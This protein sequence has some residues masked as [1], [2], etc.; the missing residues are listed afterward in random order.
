MVES[1]KL[2]G[3]TLPSFLQ[4]IWRRGH[5]LTYKKMLVPTYQISRFH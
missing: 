4:V 2:F 5:Y 1:S 3:K